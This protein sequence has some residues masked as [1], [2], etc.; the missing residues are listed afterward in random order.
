MFKN[1]T[2]AEVIAIIVMALQMIVIMVVIS[3]GIFAI[4]ALIAYI[5]R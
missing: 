5:W 1:K 3:T 4:F 2:Y